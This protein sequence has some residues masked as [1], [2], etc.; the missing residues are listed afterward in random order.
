MRTVLLF[1]VLVGTAALAGDHAADQNER[2][3][4]QVRELLPEDVPHGV[5]ASAK[6]P[7]KSGYITVQERTQDRT[8]NL[9]PNEVGLYVLE[10]LHEGYSVALYPQVSG[11][12]FSV[13]TCLSRTLPKATP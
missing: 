7:S 5:C 13:A 8:R 9:L 3:Q 12:I 10:R 11:R 1:I 2:P 6:W 4:I